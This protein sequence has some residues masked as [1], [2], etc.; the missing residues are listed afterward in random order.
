M[1]TSILLSTT[2]AAAAVAALINFWLAWRIGQLRSSEKISIGAGGHELLE[3][4]MR[5]QLNFAENAPFM[6]ALILLVELAGKGGLWLPWVA[7]I[8]L[9]GRIAHG[10]GMDGAGFAVGRTIGM[11]TTML[12]QLGMA[13]VALL[14][15]AGVI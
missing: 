14:I 1:V 10:L 3:R 15:V 6:L 12:G 13:V 7:G 4:R 11:A 9:F 2:M 5:A 8:Y